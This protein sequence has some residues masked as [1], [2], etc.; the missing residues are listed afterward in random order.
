MFYY[1]SLPPEALT[2][3]TF[4]SCRRTSGFSCFCAAFV[5]LRSQNETASILPAPLTLN[6]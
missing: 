4:D 3:M 6:P 2:R 1:R 5:F